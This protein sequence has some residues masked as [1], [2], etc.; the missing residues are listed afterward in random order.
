MTSYKYLAVVQIRVNIALINTQYPISCGPLFVDI[1]FARD[2]GHRAD[3]EKSA[4]Q[5]GSCN[6]APGAGEN[7][8]TGMG[9]AEFQEPGFGCKTQ[10]GHTSPRRPNPRRSTGKQKHDWTTEYGILPLSFS[11]KL[12]RSPILDFLRVTHRLVMICEF[13]S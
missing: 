3:V 8:A 5:F 13:R 1:Q 4:H 7:T 12:K 9:I 2:D 6:T 11:L 10:H